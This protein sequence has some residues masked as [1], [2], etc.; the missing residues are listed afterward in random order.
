MYTRLLCEFNGYEYCFKEMDT[1]LLDEFR[2]MYVHV[3]FKKC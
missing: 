1:K 3:K 2:T